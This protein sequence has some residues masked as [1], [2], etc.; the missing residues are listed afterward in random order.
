MSHNSRFKPGPT[1]AACAAMGVTHLRIVC[2]RSDCGRV[3]EIELHKVMRVILSPDRVA[4]N[5][6]PWQCKCRSINIRVETVIPKEVETP[7]PLFPIE[8]VRPRPRRTG[9][10]RTV[11]VVRIDGGP[12]PKRFA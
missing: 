10:A 11:I 6:I 7:L 1:L 2:L 8:Q 9:G 5:Q 3:Q 12:P 4:V